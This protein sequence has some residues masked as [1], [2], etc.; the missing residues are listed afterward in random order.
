MAASAS[1]KMWPMRFPHCAPRR[2][3]GSMD[4]WSLPMAASSNAGA[5]A[6]PTMKGTQLQQQS[7]EH[8]NQVRPETQR[9]RLSRR[10]LLRI[11]AIGGAVGLAGAA[12]LIAGPLS[13]A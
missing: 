1:Q 4:S 7:S 3:S 6:A 9:G 12:G 10:S 8:Q 13:V 5:D 2:V 11:S